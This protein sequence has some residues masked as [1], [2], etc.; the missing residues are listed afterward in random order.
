M[1]PKYKC[2]ADCLA[3]RHGGACLAEAIKRVHDKIPWQ[4]ARG[5]TWEISLAAVKGTKNKK[6]SWCPKCAPNAPV[7]ESEYQEYAQLHSGSLIKKAKYVTSPTIWCCR[8]HGEFSR[9][10]SNMK[11]TGTFCPICSTSLGEQRCKK[12]V[13]QLFKKE[14]KKVRLKE[15]RGLG[16]KPLELDLYN[17]ELK[18]A[19]E[20]QGVQHYQEKKYFGVNRFARQS[21]HDQRKV[22]YCRSNGIT[23]IQIQ[24]FGEITS[25]KEFRL[26][27][28]RACE[29]NKIP[30]PNDFD[31]IELDLAVQNLETPTEK[32]WKR[33][34]EEVQKRS[35]QTI[36]QKYLGVLVKHRFT[37]AKGHQIEKTPTSLF[38]GE[39]C[40]RC[41]QRPV[42]LETGFVFESLSDA[43]RH[44]G[45]PISNAYRAAKNFGATK[46][47]KLSY[48]SHEQFREFSQ[49]RDAANAFWESII[50][51]F[52]LDHHSRIPLVTCSGKT[53]PSGDSLAKEINADPVTVYSA[54]RRNG[55]VKGI[56]VFAI[57]R[58]QEAIFKSN[59]S[60]IDSFLSSRV[61]KKRHQKRTAKTI[62]TESGLIFTSITDFAKHL[63]VDNSSIYSAM[64]KTFKCR[65]TR[66]KIIDQ[67]IGVELRSNAEARSK[68]LEQ[69]FG[70]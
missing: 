3:Q 55:T 64:E 62:I 24:Q 2:Q 17:E 16:G 42:L 38:A 34:L 35:W 61:I 27:L 5:H 50:Y 39:D 40:P 36:T 4:C 14:F 18:L 56:Q 44:L 26:T 49:N 54:I 20:H 57:S 32:M 53:F 41:N 28:R 43:A 48:I 12:A 47:V 1:D 33:I 51:K 59:P 69:H 70:D 7:P 58:E 21:E 45:T 23:L 22:A 10:F 37:C 29:V 9:T 67:S 15:M 25:E 13:E 46:G 68:F 11:T 66:F 52:Q 19:I 8:V 30:I 6:G 65:N 60:A 31:S 63:K